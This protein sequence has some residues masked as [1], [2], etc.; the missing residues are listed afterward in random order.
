MS[1]ELYNKVITSNTLIK[2]SSLTSLLFDTVKGLFLGLLKCTSWQHLLDDLDTFDEH[3]L[4]VTLSQ[5]AQE[6][7]FLMAAVLAV[8]NLRELSL[9]D[10]DEVQDN[11]FFVGQLHVSHSFED[12]ASRGQSAEYQLHCF[13]LYDILSTLLDD[14][15]EVGHE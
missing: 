11:A 6:F 10:Q 8:S 4:V 13:S 1:L 5:V 15:R 3:A 2:G 7:E 14:L 9:H 12:V